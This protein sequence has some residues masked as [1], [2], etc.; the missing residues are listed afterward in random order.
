MS[1]RQWYPEPS[2]DRLA[3]AFEALLDAEDGVLASIRSECQD[4]VDDG[5]R[6]VM[7]SCLIAIIDRVTHM[8]D[9][10]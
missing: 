10:Q 6:E 8:I 3:L 9:D 4:A 2:E 5:D 7:R 1:D